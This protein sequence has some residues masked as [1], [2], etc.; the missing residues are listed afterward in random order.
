MVWVMS[1]S[2]RAQEYV[3]WKEGA[4]VFVVMVVAA[5]L[6]AA[7]LYLLEVPFGWLIG[8]VLA[9]AI[10]FLAYSYLRYGR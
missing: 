1:R 10:V 8:G 3:E 5:V 9:A 2:P 4:V 7:A 6:G